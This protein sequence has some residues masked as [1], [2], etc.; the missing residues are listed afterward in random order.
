MTG[1]ATAG[2]GLDLSLVMSALQRVLQS[3]ASAAGDH[4]RSEVEP[5]VPVGLAE[6]DELVDVRTAHGLPAGPVVDA[7]RRASLRP[8]RAVGQRADWVI[9]IMNGGEAGQPCRAVRLA[10]ALPEPLVAHAQTPPGPAVAASR[11]DADRELFA[12]QSL[13]GRRRGE[14]VDVGAARP[15]STGS[16]GPCTAPGCGVAGR[17]PP[18]GRARCRTPARRAREPGCPPRNSGRTA[19]MSLPSN[20]G[21]A[22]CGAAHAAVTTAPP[23][24]SGSPRPPRP[25]GR[26]RRTDDRIC[27]SWS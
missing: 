20:P 26:P 4:P 16:S 6:H 12:A 13:R 22:A 21:A 3:P 14:R 11:H 2:G 10:G 1:R 23:A 27:P 18:P 24:R 9:G 17:S 15:P 5:V 7:E 19:A 25:G 8:Q